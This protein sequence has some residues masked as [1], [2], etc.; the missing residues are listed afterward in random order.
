MQV[1]DLLEVILSDGAAKINYFERLRKDLI[2]KRTHPR[3]LYAILDLLGNE[4]YSKDEIENLLGGKD[5]IKTAIKVAVSTPNP[6][7]F[8]ALVNKL[9]DSK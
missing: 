8:S 1:S 3:M 2:N 7:N 5:L 4:S 6:A 9:S